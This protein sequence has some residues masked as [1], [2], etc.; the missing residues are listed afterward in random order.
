MLDVLRQRMPPPS[1]SARTSSRTCRR[2]RS[3][4]RRISGCARSR[5]ERWRVGF[6]KFATRMLG[7]IVEVQFEKQP[8]D[9]VASGEIIGSIEGFKAISDIYCVADG[10]FAGGNPDV[11]RQI[12]EDRQAIL[13]AR[14]GCMN[15]RARPMR[16]ASTSKAIA[17]CSTRPSTACSRNNK[18]TKNRMNIQHPTSQHPT[19]NERARALHHDRRLSRRGENDRRRRARAAPHARRDCASGLITNDQGSE[20]VDTAMLRAHGFATEE[21]PGGCFCCRFNSLV[22]AAEQAHAGHAAG[23][24]HRRAGRELHRSRGDGHVSAAAH[25]RRRVRRSRR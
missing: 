1:T 24:L 8:G 21:I 7:E 20:L 3:T 10:R 9:A 18:P 12:G 22:D 6:T 17:R 14:A 19:S 11:A 4:A 23:C 25:L 5:S 15:S 2:T 13:T 16:S